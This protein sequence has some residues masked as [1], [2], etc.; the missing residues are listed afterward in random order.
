MRKSPWPS[1]FWK[2]RN[3]LNVFCTALHIFCHRYFTRFYLLIYL[4]YFKELNLNG[5]V[6]SVLE[7]RILFFFLF[8]TWVS[9]LFDLSLW[10][11]SS[12]KKAEFG[13]FMRSSLKTLI[14]FAFDV[15]PFRGAYT[16]QWHMCAMEWSESL[17]VPLPVER[18]RL[19]TVNGG[20]SSSPF[21]CRHALT[22]HI[23]IISRSRTVRPRYTTETFISCLASTCM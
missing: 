18:S 8:F 22:L 15:G 7:T 9:S 4:I 17:E 19:P 5:I 10:S 12:K 2:P 20:L 1:F 6:L 11:M 23:S 13:H 21:V 16:L 14:I 3:L